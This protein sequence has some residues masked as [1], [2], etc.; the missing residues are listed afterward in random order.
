MASLTSQTVAASY[1]KLLIT[2]SNTGLSGTPTNI[3]DGDGTASVLHLSTSK[4]GIGNASPSTVLDVTGTMGVSGTS[5]L[6]GAVSIGGGYGSTGITLSDAGVIQANGAMTIDGASTL[7]GAITASSTAAIAGTTTIGGGYGATGVTLTDAGVVQ[8]NGALTVD[9]ASTLT[10]AVS[11]GAITTSGNL[12]F[13]AGTIDL[14]TQTV[15]VT[16]NSAVDAL[17]FDSNT[18]SIDASNNRVGIGTAS[19]FAQ[20]EVA[21]SASSQITIGCYDSDSNVTQ[22]ILEFRRSKHNT[23]GTIAGGDTIDNTELGLIT[24]TGVNSSDTAT[25][26]CSI[27]ARQMGAAGATYLGGEIAFYTGENDSAQAQRM[28]ILDNGNVGIGNPTPYSLL[29]ANLSAVGVPTVDWSVLKTRSAITVSADGTD[30]ML[31]MGV[32]SADYTWMQSINDDD[33]LKSLVLNPSG[34]NVGIGTTSPNHSLHINDSSGAAE[35]FLTR[36]DSTVTDGEF[37]GALTFGADDP[38]DGTFNRVASI[39]AEA[40]DDWGSNDY[41]TDIV[42]KLAGDGGAIGEKM[43]ISHDGYVGIGTSAPASTLAVHGATGGYPSLSL[44][45]SETDAAITQDEII[46]DIHFEGLD[47]DNTVASGAVIKATAA[48][49][50][51]AHNN[52]KSTKLEFFTQNNS[53]TNTLTSPRMTI[54]EVGNVGIGAPSPTGLLTLSAAAP[55]VHIISTDNDG[56]N[57]IEFKENTSTQQSKITSSGNYATSL[58]QFQSYSNSWASPGLCIKTVSDVCNVGIGTNAPGDQ[59]EVKSAAS[60][61]SRITL[62]TTDADQ[63]CSIQMKHNNASKWIITSDYSATH[64]LTVRDHDGAQGVDLPQND[65]GGWDNVSDERWK[66]DW[67]EFSG[68]LEGIKNWRAGSYYFNNLI[69]DTKGDNIQYGLIAQDVEKQLPG[70]VSEG[71]AGNDKLQK[72]MQYNKVIPYL[73]KAIQE[74]SAK[75]TALENA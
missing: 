40:G 25:P 17:N 4:V 71:T 27:I 23:I 35:I 47:A 54:D 18:L 7:T 55:T 9:G 65:S 2:D 57:T 22:G 38:S 28:T 34:G 3:E 50:W 43:R 8:M 5:A 51:T 59:L 31:M 63:D 69:T 12:D 30:T 1:G 36:D 19:P 66:S 58:L 61:G 37:L 21:A 29:N 52:N 24:F 70:A 60:T 56:T 44:V 45:R 75:V 62:N 14:S 42:F 72:R 68:A 73:V 41:A 10:G 46:G 39:H 74:L 32:G 49:N 53:D 64:A 26:A 33:T 20:L 67:S 6:A 16:L 13:N 15:D 11:C 48:D